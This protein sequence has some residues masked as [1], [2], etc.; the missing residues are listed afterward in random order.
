[1]EQDQF[2]HTLSGKREDLRRT[3]N[4]EANQ[5]RQRHYLRELFDQENHDSMTPIITPEKAAKR[6]AQKEAAGV[7][8]KG[9]PP[10]PPPRKHF[11]ASP[12]SPEQANKK[13]SWS[14]STST[15]QPKVP[16]EEVVVG[17]KVES[18]SEAVVESMPEPESESQAVKDRV[19]DEGDGGAGGHKTLSN[20]PSTSAGCL[21]NAVTAAVDP[22]PITSTTKAHETSKSTPSLGATEFTIPKEI[23]GSFHSQTLVTVGNGDVAHSN[24]KVGKD[25][26][27]TKRSF[28][29]R[30]PSK[31]G[32]Q[33]S[34]SNSS[35]KSKSKKMGGALARLLRRDHEKGDSS[36]KANSPS[37]SEV[38]PPPKPPRG[39]MDSPTTRAK[40]ILVT[41][42]SENNINN[43]AKQITIPEKP[44]QRSSQV[45]NQGRMA[46]SAENICLSS[47]PENDMYPPEGIYNVQRQQI[48]QDPNSTHSSPVR[49]PVFVSISGPRRTQSDSA[50]QLPRPSPS[51]VEIKRRE[52]DPAVRPKTH[53]P[54]APAANDE[55]LRTIQLKAQYAKLR[56]MQLQNVQRD[57]KAVQIPDVKQ[58][59]GPNPQPLVVAISKPTNLEDYPTAATDQNKPTELAHHGSSPTKKEVI[60]PI[61]AKQPFQLPSSPLIFF[62]F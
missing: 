37:P 33:G 46:K 40:K 38:G 60:F 34:S 55:N 18:E 43:N 62:D 21:I 57:R 53:Q 36:Q 3:N 26:S 48:I 44:G 1:M 10:P 24:G 47:S 27:H 35:V 12:A 56:Q 4:V 32:Q 11:P 49:S 17:V 28:L 7:Q 25:K 31:S 58:V 13:I 42:A 9:P 39:C 45:T 59:N 8:K 19:G 54:S 15:S 2:E 23:N 14:S 61:Q 29:S 51:S 5:T 16:S 20:A 6:E 41:A 30:S 22:P 50:G 52:T